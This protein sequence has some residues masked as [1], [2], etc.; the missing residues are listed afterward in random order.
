MKKLFLCFWL[1]L[2]VGVTNPAMG[3]FAG[4][5]GT[6]ADPYL[7]STP[8]HLVQLFYYLGNANLH[9]KM[10]NNIDLTNYLAV[11]GAGHNDGAGWSPIGNASNKFS[12]TFN[13]AGYKITGLW[14][15]RSG[16]DYVGLFGNADVA[17]ISNLGVEIAIAGISGN[18]YVGGLI[19]SNSDGTINDCYVVGN[20]YN[21]NNFVGGLIGYNG[22]IVNNCYVK[23][24]VNAT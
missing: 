20:I 21:G 24:N 13:G 8:D 15:N 10:S 11:G 12:G 19:G 3:Q 4:G 16:T 2:A 18:S 7:I 1:F 14:I 6:E 9:F 23:G 22:G 5:S 17:S